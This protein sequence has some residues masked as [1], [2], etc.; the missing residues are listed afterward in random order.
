MHVDDYNNY[1]E[2]PE[3]TDSGGHTVKENPSIF[4]PCEADIMAGLDTDHRK[5]LK[6]SLIVRPSG[7]I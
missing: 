3:L 4:R 2:I 7:H 1:T 5:K 6:P